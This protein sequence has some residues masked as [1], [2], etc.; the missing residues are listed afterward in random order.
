M[1]SLKQANAEQRAAVVAYLSSEYMRPFQG[2]NKSFLGKYL[3]P[4]MQKGQASTLAALSAERQKLLKANRLDEAKQNLFAATNKGEAMLQYRDVRRADGVPEST[5]RSEIVDIAG[6]SNTKAE[7]DSFLDQQYGPNGQ[8]FRQQYPKE[9]QEATEAFYNLRQSEASNNARQRKLDDTKSLEEAMATVAK[10]KEDGT[11]DARPERLEQLQAEAEAAGQTKTAKYWES[12]IAET[13]YM[14]NSED[15]KNQYEMQI[16]AGIIP[17]ESEILQNP[18]LSQEHKQAL[19]SKATDSG[20]AEPTTGISKA[21]KEEIKDF[22]K[23]R[24]GFLPMQAN[25]PGIGAM[26]YRAWTRYTQDYNAELKRNGGDTNAAA[27]FARNEFLKE[28]NKKDGEYRIVTP[29]EAAKDETLKLGTYA[30]YD[31]FGQTAPAKSPMQQIRE[32]TQ[33]PDA[34][35]SIQDALVKPN[36]YSGEDED[37]IE[38]EES[39]KT[40]GKVGTIPP[41]YYELQQQLGG[42]MSIMELLNSRM[43]A[44]GM[45]PLPKELNNIIKPVEDTFDDET[46]RYI[47]YKPN[48]TRTDIGLINSGVEPIYAGKVPAAVADDEEFQMAVTDTAGRLGIPEQHLY[49]AMSFETGGTFSPNIANAAGSGATGLI[50]FMPSTAKGL[51]T[52]TDEL[53]RM[54]RSRQMHYVEKYLSNKGIGP[55]STLDDV[56]MAILFPAAVGKSDDYVLF[57]QGAM[58]GYT[59][60]AYTQNRGL[61][62]DG[63]GSITKAEAAQKVIDHRNSMSPWRQ[64]INVRPGL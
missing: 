9:A 54:S 61:D 30:N 22:I 58:S 1:V 6:R 47:N 37:L 14:K 60:E 42:K 16:A 56:Y 38:L 57:G 15:L 31:R 11:F 49:A 4:G 25:D 43:V 62:K 20:K 32:K 48:P 2:M 41:V 26:E 45:K 52:S 46:Y 8:T 34:Y 13:A 19:L 59:G 33:G 55:N 64:P 53:S 10:D 18:A 23:Q 28:F 12:Q 36:L 29:E 3:F 27:T 50:Q 39:F 51:G 35:M 44:N 24:G 5:I 7:L 63:D 40:D 21:H 17:Q